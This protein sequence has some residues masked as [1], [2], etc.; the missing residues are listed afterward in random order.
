[1]RKLLIILLLLATIAVWARVFSGEKP[2]RLT[3][4]EQRES[5][6]EDRKGKG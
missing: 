1:M 6:G 5:V 2:K 4:E 3:P